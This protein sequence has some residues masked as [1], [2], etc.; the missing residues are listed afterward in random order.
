MDHGAPRCK[1][2]QSCRQWLQA[3]GDQWNNGAFC[4]RDREVYVTGSETDDSM[5]QALNARRPVFLEKLG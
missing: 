1:P 2:G 5:I 3:S 4:F